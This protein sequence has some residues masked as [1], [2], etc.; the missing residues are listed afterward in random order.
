M[1]KKYAV[2]FHWDYSPKKEDAKEQ[3]ENDA[4]DRIFE[5]VKEGYWQGE[6][7]TYIGKRE[8]RGWWEFKKVTE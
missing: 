8:C 5:M 3:L 7:C 4:L 6:L 2:S 1:K